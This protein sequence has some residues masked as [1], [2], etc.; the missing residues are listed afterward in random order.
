[1]IH[2]PAAAAPHLRSTS[3]TRSL[4]PFIRVPAA[5]LNPQTVEI[6]PA[7]GSSAGHDQAKLRALSRDQE[8]S[9]LTPTRFVKSTHGP[10]GFDNP[11]SVVCRGFERHGID[12]ASVPDELTFIQ[13]GQDPAHYEI[14]PRPGSNLTPEQVRVHSRPDQLWVRRRS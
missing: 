6:S 1:V 9:G 3:A 10:C 5:F 8:S 11:E 12:P 14:V 2:L 4:I 13:R 7:K